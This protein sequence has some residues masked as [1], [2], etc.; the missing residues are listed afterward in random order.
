METVTS[1]SAIS[2]QAGGNFLIFVHYNVDLYTDVVY[3]GAA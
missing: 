1:S 3:D 2:S